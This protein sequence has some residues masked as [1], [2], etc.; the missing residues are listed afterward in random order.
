MYYFLYPPLPLKPCPNPWLFV[1]ALT[2]HQIP[3]LAVYF[4][5]VS[6]ALSSPLQLIMPHSLIFVFVSPQFPCPLLPLIVSSPQSH[7][8]L[9]VSSQLSRPLLLLIV[10]A[11][12]FCRLPFC[13][14]PIPWVFTTPY[15][16]ALFSLLP[17]RPTLMFLALSPL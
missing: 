15:S 1:L 5:L 10:L 9:F 6:F 11:S 8:F 4:A 13:L 7:S 2:P 14:A 16:L 12:L 3:F 17:F